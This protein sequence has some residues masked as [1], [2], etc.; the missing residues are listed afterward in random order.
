MN[1]PSAASES[2]AQSKCTDHSMASRRLLYEWKQFQRGDHSKLGIEAGPENE[3]NIFIWQA[4]IV[5]PKDTPY[6]DGRFHLKIN[7]P[8]DY[9][10]KPPKVKME[11]PVFH[12]NISSR[13]TVCVDILAKAWSPALT[14]SNVLLSIISLLTTPNPEDPMDVHA[15]DLYTNE[16]GKY[17]ETARDWTA[18]FANFK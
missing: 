6:E 5:G 18:R 16:P 9:P 4:T 2:Q 3:S 14:T 7:Y 1:A 17:I 10:F 8:T 12:P 15:A 11:T 13:G